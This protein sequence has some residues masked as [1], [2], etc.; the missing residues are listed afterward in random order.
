MGILVVFVALVLVVVF[1]TLL[2]RMLAPSA[3]KAGEEAAPAPA[4][5]E[6]E[7]PEEILVVI[8][9]AVAEAIG[10]PTRIVQIRGL[11]PSE[12]G[13]SLEGRMLHHHSHRIR[14]RQ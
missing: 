4:M 1:I 12:L 9:A 13:W 8:A 2:P 5:G 14:G 6:D 7:L 10:K 3:G 11:T